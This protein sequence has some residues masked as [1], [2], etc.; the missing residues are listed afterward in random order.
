MALATAQRAIDQDA[1]DPWA[2]FAAGYVYIVLRKFRPA[3]DELNE[4]IERNPNFAMA[5]MMRGCAYA[6]GGFGDEGLK[7][8][9][10]ATR[11]SPRDHTQPANFSITG[12]CHFIA[13]RFDEAV[14]FEQRAIQLRPN[15]GT[16]L[17]TLASA[18][19]LAGDQET[20]VAALG[21]AKRPQPNLT[22][23]WVEKYQPIVRAEDRALYVE[24]LRKAG[25]T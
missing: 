20:A 21:E 16:A 14:A 19:A 7:H 10:V 11:L 17:R 2:H 5:H 9:A 6:Y 12:L 23:D 22:V 15:F 13:R 3:L 1:S 25:L 18:A 4:S 24:G 8:L